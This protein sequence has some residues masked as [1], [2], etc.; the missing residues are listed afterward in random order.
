MHRTIPGQHVASQRFQD[1][2][3]ARNYLQAMA[4]TTTI[5][6]EAAE[7][8]GFIVTVPALPEV[9]TQGSPRAEALANALEVIERVIEHRQARGEP[10]PADVSAEAERVTVAA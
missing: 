3:Q 5:V 6:L 8:G 2:L 4:H 7:E 9:G 10:I 1:Y